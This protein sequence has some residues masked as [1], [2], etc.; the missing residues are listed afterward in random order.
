[1]KQHITAEQLDELSERGK[2]ILAEWWYPSFG[3]HFIKGC[4][5]DNILIFTNHRNPKE[6]TEEQERKVTMLW[7]WSKDLLPLLSI[8]QM[9]KFLYDHRPDKRYKTI[10]LPTVGDCWECGRGAISPE[11]FCN[12]L[13]EAVKEVLE[14]K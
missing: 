1:M 2:K 3:D 13:W 8:G 7:K 9:I 12:E 6:A 14:K 5:K 11:K 10:D 4:D